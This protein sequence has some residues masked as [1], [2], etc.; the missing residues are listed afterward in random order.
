VTFDQKLERIN[1]LLD[2]IVEEYFRAGNFPIENGYA[3]AVEARAL[4]ADMRC[5]E[6]A[7]EFL[8]F[9]MFIQSAFMWLFLMMPYWIT[10]FGIFG[11]FVGFLGIQRDSDIL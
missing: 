3:W 4:I 10:T 6:E 9:S 7:T 2:V 8:N 5:I 11:I 1:Y